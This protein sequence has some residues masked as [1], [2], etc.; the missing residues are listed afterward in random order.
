MTPSALDALRATLARGLIVLC[1]ALTAAAGPLE[2]Q[3]QRP[4]DP[5]EASLQ[6]WSVEADRSRAIIDRAE[7]SDEALTAMRQRLEGYREEARALVAATAPR[8]A[9]LERELAALGPP[10]EEGQ[11]ENEAL[12]AE[13]AT[14]S[15]RL[16][17]ATSVRAR[18]NAFIDRFTAQ[19]EEI[20]LLLRDRIVTRVL[21]R[22]DTPLDPTLWIEAAEDAASIGTRLAAEATSS[23]ANPSVREQAIDTAPRALLAL[24]A[25]AALLIVARRR[26]LG[27]VERIANDPDTTREQRIGA[28][29]VATL[30]RLALPVLS[31]YLLGF[32][33][34]QSGLLGPTLDALDRKSVV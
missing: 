4:D 6:V 14:L 27:W 12:A 29:A 13:R 1:L 21:Q 17:N 18:A 8:I 22:G 34:T 19:I 33:V 5:I 16:A 11:T 15:E 32:A 31:L 24:I 10:P 30:A 25:G 3:A 9:Q 2:A 28:G 20:N 26:V 7:A 23:I